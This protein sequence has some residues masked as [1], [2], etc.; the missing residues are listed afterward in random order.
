MYDMTP[1]RR[2]EVSGP[3]AVDLLQK[4]TIGD[5]SKKPGAVTYT[6]L[7][8]SHGGIRSDITVARLD[9]ETFEV[10]STDRSTWCT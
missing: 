4:L 8:D 7:L 6:L 10:A 2:L 9:E 5:V 1:L 3:G